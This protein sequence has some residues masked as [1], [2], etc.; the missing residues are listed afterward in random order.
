M[1]RRYA[2][3][4]EVSVERSIGEI[5][6]LILRYGAESFAYQ[7]T[8]TDIKIAFVLSTL[9]VQMSIEFPGIEEFA[10]T[11]TGKKRDSNA[12]WSEWEK[13]S[14]RRVRSLAAVIK[15]KFIAIDDGVATIEQE[16]LP[17]IVLHD[18]RRVGD[19]LIPRLG[20]IV[21]GTLA[22]PAPK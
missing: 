2:E 1:S 20:E 7:E 18:G 15:A 3:G 9:G 10:F 21:G 11:P 6:R 17:Y 16:F 5:K 8:P 14:K 12:K 13:E 4:T 19:C 22:L